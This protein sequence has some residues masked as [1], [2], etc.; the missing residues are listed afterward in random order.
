M[1]S[2]R[3]SGPLPE[4]PGRLPEFLLKGL[5]KTVDAAIA[6]EGGDLL[7]AATMIDQEGPCLL[8]TLRTQVF[9][10]PVAEELAEA[11]FQLVFVH[12][13]LLGDI[14][15]DKM[16]AQVLADHLPGRLDPFHLV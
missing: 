8:H 9:I 6:G 7:D 11:I 5:D 1:D 14:P 12:A 15:D 16:I 2:R 10:D 3:S 13:H 4:L